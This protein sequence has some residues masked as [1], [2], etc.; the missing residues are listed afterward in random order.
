MELPCQPAP[1]ELLRRH[2]APERVALHTF[3]QIDRNRRA[4]RKR[5][6]KPEVVVGEAGIG[7]ELVM[8]CEQADRAPAGDE[9]HPEPGAGAEAAHD[10]VVDL[11]IVEDRIDPLAAAALD[12]PS[13]LRCGEG[14]RL[15]DQ[16]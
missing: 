6:R 2:D 7:H 12:H 16:L 10:L 14:H 4:R 1:L 5:L 8:R 13:A 11:G 15:P 9:R 3:G